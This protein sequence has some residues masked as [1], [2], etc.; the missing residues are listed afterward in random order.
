M[1]SGQPS[2]SN[3]GKQPFKENSNKHSE[4]CRE[5]ISITPKEKARHLAGFFFG[6][7]LPPIPHQ[8]F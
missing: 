7:R 2:S 1:G 6:D 8:A 4:V 3:Q 5:S